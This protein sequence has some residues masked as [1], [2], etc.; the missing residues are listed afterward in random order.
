MNQQHRTI[1][2]VDDSPEDRELY[3]RYLLSDSDHSYTI[4]EA[5]L[6]QQGLAL[7]QQHQ[8]DIIILD[9]RLPDLDGLEFLA[10][11]QSYT[12]TP[13]LA[14]IVVTG[15]GNE[16]TAVQAIKAGA[17]DYLVKGQITP[18][19]FQLAVNGAIAS[20]QLQT[21]LQQRIDRERLVRQISQQ[22]HQS[23]DLNEV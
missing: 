11:L 21:Q 15:Q 14:V 23:L 7:W 20:V 18:E 4:L 19:K 16:G 17:Q 9:Y 13:D 12:Q 8:P 6:G 1:L 10:Q 3:R 2:I 22:I 5:P